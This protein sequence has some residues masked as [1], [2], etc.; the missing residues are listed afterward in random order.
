MSHADC[1]TA[2]ASCATE[3]PCTS[4]REPSPLD[5]VR[6]GLAIGRN[7]LLRERPRVS[8]VAGKHGA[9]ATPQGLVCQRPQDEIHGKVRPFLAPAS[10]GTHAR[11]RGRG[12]RRARAAAAGVVTCATS[13]Q[14]RHA[15]CEPCGRAACW[16]GRRAPTRGPPS[17]RRSSPGPG[18]WRTTPG[19]SSTPLGTPAQR[20]RRPPLPGHG[21]IDG[22]RDMRRLGVCC[23]KG[24]LC[25]AGPAGDVAG[26]FAGAQDC[27]TPVSCPASER[28][29][30]QQ[31]AQHPSPSGFTPHSRRF[32]WAAIR[33]SC[34]HHDPSHGRVLGQQ[35]K[36][37]SHP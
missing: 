16:P 19:P 3:E 34:Y 30:K 14:A 23:N 28:R 10:T 12:W 13:T 4:H 31:L 33:R 36:R 17:P 18:A 9:E 26:A 20:R 11:E 24:H 25:K 32:G 15:P 8:H 1:R 5:L 37:Q 6:V 29:A 2:N 22:V 35:G 27:S 21:A 7:A